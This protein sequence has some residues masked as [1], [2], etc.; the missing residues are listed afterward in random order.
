MSGVIFMSNYTLYQGDCLELMKQIPD[1]SIDMVLC[2]LPYGKTHNQWDS[3][4]PF[5]KLWSSYNR[6]IKDNGAIVLFGQGSFSAQLICSNLKNYRYTLIWNKIRTSG[7]LN[8]KRIPLPQH[9]D[10]MVFY[11]KL[12]TYNPQMWKGDKPSHRRGKK[13]EQKGIMQ[14]KGKVYGK[15][16]AYDNLPST[17]TDMKYPTSII[18]IQNVVVNNVHP[19]QKPVELMEWLIKTYTNEGETVLDNCMGSGSTGIACINTNRNFIGIELD[20]NYF[21]IAK[22]RIEKHNVSKKLF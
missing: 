2:D 14:T 1:K 4:I 6:I 19:T 10:I 8:A 18:T 13:N 16:V 21:N 15:Y 3:I 12:P 17:H 20:E 9:E 5:N 11:K 7:F 22:E